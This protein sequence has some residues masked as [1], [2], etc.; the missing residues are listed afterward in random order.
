MPIRYAPGPASALVQ[1][2]RVVVVDPTVGASDLARLWDVLERLSP[3]DGMAAVLD[4]VTG[5][6]D[7]TWRALPGFSVVVLVA[8]DPLDGDSTS[9][10]H[11]ASRGELEVH[12]RASE[13]ETDV[14]GR[15]VTTWVEKQVAGVQTI[16]LGPGGPGAGECLLTIVS[17]IVPV[18]T[19]RWDVAGAPLSD[20]AAEASS[21]VEPAVAADALVAEAPVAEATVE[22]NAEPG[23]EQSVEPE[24]EP[25]S[26]LEPEQTSANLPE[27]GQTL[28][29]VPEDWRA[30]SSDASDASDVSDVSDAAAAETAD[31][32]AHDESSLDSPE[33]A[34]SDTVDVDQVGSGTGTGAGTETIDAVDEAPSEADLDDRDLDDSTILS[35]AG[36]VVP[37]PVRAR[38][39]PTPMPP[40]PPPPPATGDGSRETPS[41]GEG[42]TY[43]VVVPPAPPAPP[44]QQ[45]ADLSA[46]PVS[47]PRGPAP[48]APE[49]LA[50]SCFFGHANPPV[51]MTCS[52]CGGGLS[53]NA[54]LVER[55]SLGRVRFSHGEVVDLVQP[56]VVG[57][58]PMP[59]S[60]QSPGPR[61]VTVVSPSQDISRSHLEVRLEGWHVLLVDLDTMNGTTLVRSGQAPR[62]LH[63]HEPTL[64]AE[65]DVVDLGDGVLLTFEGIA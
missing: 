39:V 11:V 57:R 40:V 6:L 53:P 5:V 16:A 18:S 22:P 28:A 54:Q 36:P 50:R 13:G 56:V 24:E 15:S 58:F 33:R 34:G 38:S 1:P 29:D 48:R 19:L 10:A 45:P 52:Q 44:A 47:A 25:G 7:P 31:G 8:G 65:G 37:V 21:D 42:G 62:R 32:P 64:V 55:P 63:P 46:P 51:R 41:A 35:T 20:T 17:G 27:F 30:E 9:A 23:V 26:R 4:A 14:V 59:Q 43:G 60:R 49:I 2:G 61:L 3:G 12:V